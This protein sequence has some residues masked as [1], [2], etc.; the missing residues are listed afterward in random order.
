MLIRQ[1]T[2]GVSPGKVI[3]NLLVVCSLLLSSVSLAVAAPPVPPTPPAVPPTHPIPPEV[4]IPV[5]PGAAA[6]LHAPD[7]RLKVDFPA[8]AIGMSIEARYKAV[9]GDMPSFLFHQFEL[10]AWDVANPNAAVHAFQKPLTVTVQYTDQEV[11]P[12]DESLLSLFR[13]DDAAGQWAP[14]PSQVYTETNVIV[15]QI[16]HFSDYGAGAPRT[17]QPP[18]PS[19]QA[20]QSDRFTGAA[21]VSYPI[22]VPPG[23]GGLTPSISLSY[24]SSGVDGADSETQASW[25]GMGW[26]LDLGHITRDMRGKPEQPWKHVFNLSL[27]GVGSELVLDADGNWHTSDERF[28]RIQWQ[29]PNNVWVVTTQ[30]GTQ[31]TFAERLEY[32]RYQEMEWETWQW[33]LTSVTDVHGNTIQYSYA[34]DGDKDVDCGNQ[35]T[36]ETPMAAYPNT[37]TWAGGKYRVLFGRQPRDDYK[38]EWFDQCLQH[39]FQQQMLKTITVQTDV[40]LDGQWQPLRRYELTYEDAPG[41]RIFPGVKWDFNDTPND[42]NDDFQ[43]DPTLVAIQQV[44]VAGGGLPAYEFTYKDNHLFTADNGYGGQVSFN[45][46]Y[47]AAAEGPESGKMTVDYQHFVCHHGGCDSD[48]GWTNASFLC[49]ELDHQCKDAYSDCPEAY[50]EQKLGAL[51]PLPYTTE[52]WKEIET[53]SPGRAYNFKVRVKKQSGDND[54]GIQ[55]RAWDGVQWHDVTPFV[56]IDGSQW[57]TGT[58]QVSPLAS[59]LKLYLVTGQNDR[60]GYSVKEFVLTPLPTHYRVT[61]KTVADDLSYEATYTYQYENPMMNT[62]TCDGATCLH[63]ANTEFWGHG[64]VIEIDPLGQEQHTWYHQDAVLKG[65]VIGATVESDAGVTLQQT[66]NLYQIED[67]PAGTNPCVDMDIHFSYL[68]ET[69]ATTCGETGA[70]DSQRTAYFYDD[71]LQGG[72]QYGNV[73]RIVEYDGQDQPYR[74]TLRRY[75]PN[76][77]DYL[78]SSPAFEY[79]YAG[80][81]DVQTEYNRDLAES[82][83]WYIYDDEQETPNPGWNQP[84]GSKGELRAVRRY[85]AAKGFVDT[86]YWHDDWGNVTKE[87]IYNSYGTDI[88][89]A[90]VET[91]TTTIQYDDDVHTFPLQV[92]NPKTQ[93]ATA[94]FYGIGDP[95][96]GDGL[97]GQVKAMTDAN[98]LTTEY[99][100]D[101]FGRV[102]RVKRPG[103]LGWDVGQVSTILEYFEPVSDQPLQFHSR[104]RDDASGDGYFDSWQFYNGLGQLL[105]SQSQAEGGM[106]VSDVEYDELGRQKYVYL[107]YEESTSPLGDYLPSPGS[108]YT[109]YDYDALGRV[110]VVTNPDGTQTQ[111]HYGVFT[112]LTY[113][114]VLDANRHRKQLR[115]D[116]WGRLERVYEIAGN[117]GTGWGQEYECHSPLLPGEEEWSVYATTHYAYDVRDNLTT[118]NDAMNNVTTMQYDMLGRKTY[119]DDPDMG[120]WYY[121]Y[122]ALGNLET[123]TDA[124]GQVI[125]FDY[126]VL[127]RL[128]GKDYGNDG[129]A[130]ALYFYDGDGTCPG[131]PAS[132]GKVVGQR[133]A[134][135]SSNS[136]AVYHYDDDRGRLSAED[137]WIDGAPNN[138]YITRYVYDAMDRVVTMTYPDNEEVMIDYDERGLP[139]HLVGNDL[140]VDHADYNALGQMDLLDFGPA[141]GPRMDFDYYPAQVGNNRLEQIQVLDDSQAFLQLAYTYDNVG[142]VETIEDGTNGFQVQHF[143]YDALDRLTHVWTT[144]G[145]EG[146]YDR[147]YEYDQVGNLHYHS[148]LGYYYQYNGSQPHAVT[149]MSTTPNGAGTQKYWY[150]NNGNM[151]GRIEDG[152]TYDQDWDA[153]NRLIRVTDGS[154]GQITQFIYDGDG[155]LVEEISPDGY[156]LYVGNYYEEFVDTAPPRVVDTTPAPNA[157][158]VPLDTTLVV[159]FSETVNDS[160]PGVFELHQDNGT[161]VPAGIEWVRDATNKAIG[162]QL[163]PYDVLSACRPYTATVSGYQDPLGHVMAGT[164][165]WTFETANDLPQVMATNP[166]G[167]AQDVQPGPAT[168]VV[169][170]TEEVTC[171]GG[172][173][174]SIVEDGA[175]PLPGSL[176][177]D[178]SVASFTTDL[179][180]CTVY[181]GLA[182]GFEDVNCTESETIAPYGWT[183]ETAAVPPQVQA[184]EPAAGA[185][186]APLDQIIHVTFDE[187]VRC[188]GGNCLAVTNQRRNSPVYGHMAM[189][190]AYTAVFTPSN[191]LE[192]STWHVVTATGFVDLACGAPLTTPVTWTFETVHVPPEVAEVYPALGATCVPTDTAPWVR[193]SEQVSPSSSLDFSLWVTGTVPQEVPG[194]SDYYNFPPSCI[195][196]AGCDWPWEAVFTPTNLLTEHVWFEARVAGPQDYYGNALLPH[197]WIF[198]YAD[199]TPPAVVETEP[200]DKAVDVYPDEPLLAWFGEWLRRQSAQSE[201]APVFRVT[202]PGGPVAGQVTFVRELTAVSNNSPDTGL[203]FTP[204]APLAQSTWYTAVVSGVVD[205]CGN[206]MNGSHTWT[207]QTACLLIGLSDLP[208][209]PTVESCDAAGFELQV[210]AIPGAAQYEWR[211]T[212]AGGEETITPGGHTTTVALPYPGESTFVRVRARG[213][214]G[215]ITPWSAAVE[216]NWEVCY[217]GPPVV[218]AVSPLDGAEGVTVTAGLVVTFNEVVYVGPAREGFAAPTLSLAPA[219]GQPLPG[220]VAVARPYDRD[221]AWSVRFQPLCLSQ[222][223]DPLHLAEWTTYQAHLE[224]V[225]DSHGHKLEPGSQWSFTTGDFTPPTVV[226]SAPAGGAFGQPPSTAVAAF[227]SEPL[228]GTEGVSFEVAGPAGPVFG[229]LHYDDAYIQDGEGSWTPWRLYFEPD[230]N[231]ASD[232]IYTATVAG[233]WDLHGLRMEGSHTWHFATQTTVPFVVEGTSPVA[234]AVGVPVTATLS[235]TFNKELLAGSEELVSFQVERV[236]VPN[237]GVEPGQVVIQGQSLRFTPGEP[238]T[239]GAVYEARVV[240]TVSFLG[241]RQEA[242]YRWAFETLDPS[243]PHVA[244]T[245]PE[246]GATSVPLDS[247]VTVFFDKALK[248]GGQN[249]EFV[250]AGPDGQVAGYLSWVR[251]DEDENAI[252]STALTTGLGQ[253]SYDSGGRYLGYRGLR[254]RPLQPLAAETAYRATVSGVE[255][256]AGVPLEAPYSWSFTTGAG[257]GVQSTLPPRVRKYYFFN[258]QRVAQRQIDEFGED[259]LYWL[260]GDQLGSTSLVLCGT[261]EGCDGVAEGEVVAESRHYPYGEERWSDGTLPT[262]YKFTGQRDAGL[263]L[264]HMGARFYDSYLNRFLSPDSIIPQPANPQSFNRYSYVEG[265]PCRYIDATGHYKFDVHH[266]RTQSWVWEL[267]MK[268]FVYR[269]LPLDASMDNLYALIADANNDVDVEAAVEFAT[270]PGRECGQTPDPSL[271]G[272]THEQYYHYPGKADAEARLMKAIKGKNP[273]AFGRALHSYQDYYAHTL[274]GFTASKGDIGSLFSNCPEC[275]LEES[276][277][278]LFD[279]ARG[280]GH[281]GISW[282]DEFDLT[283]QHDIDMMNGTKWYILLFLVEYYDIDLEQFLADNGLTDAD[284]VQGEQND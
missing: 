62:S 263:G 11:E 206:T 141:N 49:N 65:K 165:A 93:T 212:D 35:G 143:T 92:T 74:T 187:P 75:V 85:D 189:A 17:D 145:G 124:K 72:E 59:E 119:M 245:T 171:P 50:R 67:I 177:T 53:F 22:E 248:V 78:V 88:A 151:T 33:F 243:P 272:A 68:S 86:R 229:L 60:W 135:W 204:D 71:E 133:T 249:V 253:N 163:G 208:P 256:L 106:V 96:L 205:F 98:G 52:A 174:I 181:Q 137:R 219:G 210:A 202:G 31:Y 173:C 159:T 13:W 203:K 64:H 136:W 193:F 190:D 277:G 259:V 100:Y 97:F 20:F 26:D 94:S 220:G 56:P 81:M 235:I 29:Q 275:F 223:R 150:D 77:T 14:V 109:E 45:Y 30:D 167:G 184:S 260:A 105:Q 258:G 276:Y 16:D 83:T 157:A 195:N 244:R 7:G 15:A 169:T 278:D 266:T 142:N 46:D 200:E 131:C 175:P 254:F 240:G 23:P 103:D 39:P 182:A 82:A 43:G 129:T 108:D 110:S 231:L 139:T 149:H 36:W 265:N 215:C 21:S 90:A 221:W 2:A 51:S 252:G 183:F 162:A 147:T 194:N 146:G 241:D 156:T 116:V 207:F 176:T 273:T 196:A 6:T 70:C 186:G 197:S 237:M 284:W 227:A 4:E 236:D 168:V 125:G 12:F 63:K 122:D 198:G 55:L 267:E 132:L 166:E 218:V 95:D 19:V 281:D 153:E 80:E 66:E 79:L 47:W 280:L 170:L 211:V 172:D 251:G 214:D 114:D 264:Y 76:T 140:Y 87:E 134:M 238:W 9:S 180:E 224:G 138:P 199:E 58:F 255:N 246:I 8:G 191:G 257:A 155:A 178:G 152:V 226:G 225:V 37:V 38:G 268:V 161:S 209:S 185:T 57:I 5:T 233:A 42:P 261:S 127:N 107:P 262:D 101:E 269:D 99:R 40:D 41:A 34:K 126:D 234:G 123:Q 201:S 28:W 102:T 271:G 32:L 61:S 113:D 117:C 282:P 24:N 239:P 213:S 274:N 89:F 84:V 144:N 69:R 242:A 112:P 91:R 164:Y 216:L 230:G 130:E 54:D 270:C 279:R 73:T 222:D 188:D 111:H 121:S 104:Q 128:V 120:E 1:S 44:G 192:E 158:D 10:T 250:L 25:A 115:Y 283:D 228:S 217:P 247:D 148:G 27:N 154:T 179:A 160:L 18:L 48:L 232:S 3:L 118:V